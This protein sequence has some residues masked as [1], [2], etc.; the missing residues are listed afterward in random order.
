MKPIHS[1]FLTDHQRR[2]QT[3]QD[4]TTN[5][6]LRVCYD[7]VE[8]FRPTGVVIEPKHW[9]KGKQRV[10][11]HQNEIA[12]NVRLAQIEDRLNKYKMKLLIEGR[13]TDADQIIDH[14]FATGSTEDAHQ[15]FEEQFTQHTG[16]KTEKA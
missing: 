6:L 11:K 5:V 10:R 3:K 13:P 16:E 8:R 7:R 15:F 9:D 4:G 2:G 14:V 12:F 1:S